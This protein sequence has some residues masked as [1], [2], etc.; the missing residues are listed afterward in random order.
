MVCSSGQP[1]RDPLSITIQSRSLECRRWHHP[2][3]Y[4]FRVIEL[5][6][7]KCQGCE[8]AKSHQRCLPLL[9]KITHLCARCRQT[10]GDT[11]SKHD[12]VSCCAY[13]VISS[14]SWQQFV[15]PQI[16]NIDSATRFCGIARQRFHA[17][18]KG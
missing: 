8:I 10:S 17:E 4:Q 11:P 5:I 3:F 12:W 1:L 13:L 7:V 2:Q 6:F 15:L 9:R 18:E 16:V 14:V